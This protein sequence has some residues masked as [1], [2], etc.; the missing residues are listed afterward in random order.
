MKHPPT[1]GLL[2]RRLA[3]VLTPDGGRDALAEA[4]SGAR[5]RIS[6]P[7]VEDRAAWDTVDRQTRQRL[8]EEARKVL[9]TPAPVLRGSDW[10]RTFRDGVRTA[11]EDAARALR[12]RAALLAVAAVLT[13]EAAPAG[14]P[15]GSAPYLDATADALLVLLE[16]STWCWAP[17]D[18]FA[19]EHAEMLPD[20]DR[21]FL[22]LGAA[23]TALLLAWADHVLG[24]RWDERVPGLRRRIRREV[25]QRVLGPFRDVRDWHWIGRDGSAHNWNAW[26]HHAVLTCALLLVEDDA[27]RAGLVRLV[28]E[29]LD[30][31]LAVLPDDGS[32][33]EGVAYWW[34]GAGQLLECL[35][36]LADAGGPP[37]DARDLPVFRELIRYPHRMHLG[38]SWYVN[39]GDAPARSSGDQPWHLLF[40]WGRL[41]GDGEVRGH[42]RA[43]SHR[44][45]TGSAHPRQGLGRALAGL[46]DP[47]WRAATTGSK[48]SE[49][50]DP[51]EGSWLPRDVWLPRAQL[52]VTRERAGTSEGLTLAVKG[53]HNEERHNH[54]DVGSYWV[55]LDGRPMIVDIGKPTYTAASFGPDRYEAWP[56]RSSWHNVPEPGGEQ[57]PGAL[58]AATEAA[59]DLGRN[60]TAWRADL[61]GAYPDGLVDRWSRRTRL[62]RATGSRPAH[63]VVEDEPRPAPDRFLLRH[64]LAGRVR[65]DDGFAVVSD[66]GGRA[67]RMSWDPAL[68]EARA[69]VRSLDDP[70]LRASWGDALTRLTLARRSSA[71]RSAGE[72]ARVRIE[73]AG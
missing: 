70:Q 49:P 33:D 17:H 61:A 68:L 11:Y 36:L 13:N 6:A 29:G 45:G 18:R 57:L 67:L 7:R 46:T 22:D 58:H 43:S 32:V 4:L 30:H 54:L 62:V 65:L 51:D 52:L 59:V 24:V 42:A 27:E 39:V 12:E 34:L 71:P 10:A 31:Y 5:W 64:V 40:H 38:D 73:R 8:L 72:P 23:E 1:T 26:I 47:E 28:V 55:A 16:A 19:A 20:P 37:L 50:S 14:A 63:I 66:E 2:H 48:T 9:G 15:P 53:G 69:E 3:G 60:A 44:T 56:L 35:D 41:L 25:T 21:P